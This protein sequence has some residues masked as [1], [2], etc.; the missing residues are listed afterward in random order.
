ME[1]GEGEKRELLHVDSLKEI[2]VA[3]IMDQ[4]TYDSFCPECQLIQVSPGGWLEEMESFRP[5]LLFLESAWLGKDNLWYRKLSR[6]STEFIQLIE[7]CKKKRIPIVFWNKEDPVYTKT[8]MHVAQLSDFVFTTDVDSVYQYKKILGHN[9]IYHM[10]FASQPAIYNPLENGERSQRC[11]FAGA[12]Y[13]KYQH[14]SQMFEQIMDLM[15]QTKGIDIYDRNYGTVEDEYQFPERYT[16]YILGKLDSKDVGDAYRK[17]QIGINMNSIQQSQSMFARRVFE[18]LASNMIV[19]GNYSRGLCNYFGDLTISTDDMKS[20]IKQM[21]LYMKDKETIHKYRLL[22][23]RKVF[24]QHLYED[25]FAFLVEKVFR[26]NLRFCYPKIN[27]LSKCDTKEEV[28]HVIAMFHKQRYENKELWIV[29]SNKEIKTEEGIHLI[30]ANKCRS[31]YIMGDGDS[32]IADFNPNDYYGTYYLNDLILNTRYGTFDVIG[33]ASYYYYARYKLNY[34]EEEVYHRCERL[35]RR[36]CI[37]AYSFIKHRTLEEFYQTQ[38]MSAPRMLAADEFHYCENC[39]SRDFAKVEDLQVYDQ[40]MSLEEFVTGDLNLEDFSQPLLQIKAKEFITHIRPVAEYTYQLDGNE[41]TIESSIASDIIRYTYLKDKY[42]VNQYTSDG[43]IHIHFKMLGDLSSIGACVFLDEMGKKIA[44]LFSDIQNE[45]DGIIPSGAKYFSLAIR[46][47][48]G[49]KCKLSEITIHQSQTKKRITQV[50]LHSDVLVI[51]NH[52]PKPD[53][54]YRNMFLHKRL[55]G[56]KEDGKVFDV[57]SLTHCNLL[58]REYEGIPVME[59]EN[60]ALNSLLESGKIKTVCVHFMNDEIWNIIKNHLNH[61]RLLVWIHG[62]EI[63]PWYRRSFLYHTE[64]E[65]QKASRVSIARMNLWNQIFIESKRHQ[66]QF[67]I[68][69]NYFKKMIEEDYKIALTNQLCSV[70]PN[71]IDT[72]LFSYIAKPGIQRLKLISIRPYASS[73]YAN[74]LTVKAILE[75]SRWERFYELSFTIIGAGKLFQQTIEPIKEFKNVSIREAFLRQSEIADLYHNH[76]IILIPT[77]ADTQGVSRDEA[78]SCGV[79]PITCKIAAIPEF[80][81]EECGLL[82]PPEDA[83]TMAECVKEMY[84]NE[85]RFL[86]LSKNAANR[87]RTQTAK[88]YTVKKELELILQ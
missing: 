10:H 48:G 13:K 37:V 43:K 69:S 85:D 11:C 81:D 31:T 34:F 46:H 45:I 52:Y 53:D 2:R 19:I 17:Y 4:F 86:T 83:H 44:P 42:K 54:L 29:T 55:L 67:I 63:Q 9:R 24:S 14:R 73:V 47:K 1:H 82:V 87:V 39:P 35:E 77:R 15:I 23:F 3:G 61:V 8:F 7:Y 79:V 78:M 38:T 22:G 58:Y 32:Y 30:E 12:Y 70:I 16:P 5:H 59:G 6:L 66:I 50:C 80:V 71:Y 64:E 21:N 62:A 33:K 26:E 28:D 68:V 57:F 51:T 72:T 27:V 18:M 25:R 56:Y 36:R 20:M 84:Y 74:D 75:L 88:E 76:G 60:W 65:K 40:G 49:G 41:C